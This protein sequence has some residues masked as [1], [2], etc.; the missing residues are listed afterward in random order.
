MADE[1]AS[2]VNET[3][4]PVSAL[5]SPADSTTAGTKFDKNGVKLEP[6]PSDDPQDPLNW[7]MSKKCINLAI[8]CLGSFA[9]TAQSGANSAGVVVQAMVYGVPPSDMINTVRH[10]GAA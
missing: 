8:L 3:H 2:N 1:K 10:M 4:A 6:Q 5:P 9:G 7:P